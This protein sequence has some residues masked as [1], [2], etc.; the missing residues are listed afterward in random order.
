[1]KNILNK[2]VAP[3]KILGFLI[4]NLGMI[5]LIYV[6][7]FHLEETVL[8]YIAYFLSAYAL[9][10]FSVWFYKTCKFSNNYLKKSNIYKIYQKKHKEVMQISLIISLSFNFIYGI[11]KLY[12]GIYYKSLWFITFAI[13]YLLLFF[14]KMSLLL[15]VRKYEVGK[16]LVKEY[17]KLKHIGF[18]LLLFDMILSIMI[19]L[20]I[21][22]NGEITYNGYL[23][24]IVALYDFYLI[25]S[26]FV[27]VFKYR[28]NHSPVLIA[29]KCISLTVA[30]VSIVSLEVAMISKFGANDNNFKFM[31]LGV[32]G[33]CVA[34][35]NSFMA[36]YMILKA[37]KYLKK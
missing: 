15:N 25:I 6:F 31:M 36:I 3:N 17:Q 24:Y 22:Q 23:I 29:S 11:L 5:L 4:F 33:L 37:K 12:F 16:N 18:I 7:S 32:T 9:I 14:M 1:M 28:N 2:I 21:K 13:Y 34:L 8:A 26:A 20:I 35:I 10:I 19:L 27:N 30:L